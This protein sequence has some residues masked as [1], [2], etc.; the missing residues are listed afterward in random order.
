MILQPFYCIRAS[1]IILMKKVLLLLTFVMLQYFGFGQTYVFDGANSIKGIDTDDPVSFSASAYSSSQIDLEFKTN[2]Y[3]NN[4]VIVYDLDGSFSAP[5]G[6]PPAVGQAFA[7]GTLIYNGYGSDY[8]HKSLTANTQYYYKAWSVD[9][10]NVYS[11]GLTIDETTSINDQSV[12]PWTEDFENSGNIPAGW[13]SEFVTGTVVWEYGEG[14]FDDEHPTGAQGGTYN[15]RFFSSNKGVKTKIITPPLDLSQMTHPALFFWHTQEEWN[16]DQDELRLYYKNAANGKWTLI[17]GQEYTNSISVWT[18]ESNIDLPSPSAHYYIAFEGLANYGY[19][20]CVDNVTVSEKVLSEPSYHVF[21][22]TASAHGESQVNLTWDDNDGGSQDADGFLISGKT[23]TGSHYLPV[24]GTDPT[25]H[26][27]WNNDEFNVKVE[28][29]LEAYNVTG[30]SPSTTYDFKIYPYT[31][32]GSTIDYKTGGTIP[33]S[34]ATTTVSIDTDT[35]VTDPGSQPASAT[36]SSIN[37]TEISGFKIKIKD[38][39]SDGLPTHVTNIRLKPYTT[40]TAPW[41][42]NIQNISLYDGTTVIS[43]RWRSITD[44]YIDIPFDIGDLTIPNNGEKTISISFLLITNDGVT[45]NGIISFMVDAS[46][47]GFTA[48]PSGSTFSSSF[49]G[50]DFHSNNFTLNVIATKLTFKESVSDIPVNNIMTPF[51]TLAFTDK[52]E[53]VDLDYPNEPIQITAVGATLVGS[54]Q[55]VNINS[56]TG[57][58]IFNNIQFS[59]A[60]SDIYLNA[61]DIDNNLGNNTIERSFSF[62]VRDVG[63][64][65]FISEVA[66]PSDLSGGR[67]VELFNPTTS[68]IDLNSGGYYLELENN[69]SGTSYKVALKGTILEKSEYVCAWDDGQVPSS[70]FLT[71]VG[72]PN[73]DNTYWHGDGNDTYSLYK[74]VDCSSAGVLID[75]FGVSGEDGSGKNWEYTDSHAVRKREIVNPNTVWTTSEWVISEA[76]REQITPLY[77][78]KESAWD[79]S[80]SNSS[81]HDID[82]YQLGYIPDASCN[83]VIQLGS[84]PSPVI[85]KNA[86]CHNLKIASGTSVTVN[87]GTSLTVTGSLSSSGQGSLLL[88]ADGAHGPSS[89]IHNT[90]NVPATVESYFADLSKWYLLSPPIDNASASLFLGQYLDYWNEPTG[91][92]VDITNQNIV[93]IPGKGYSLKKEV[94][95]NISYL[96]NLNNGDVTISGLRRT[97]GTYAGWNLIGNPYPSVLAV[98]EMSFGNITAAVSVWP[99]NGA[100]YINYSKGTGGNSEARYIQPGQ[101]F[102]VQIPSGFDNQSLTFTN[103]MRTHD[104]LGSLDKKLNKEE[105]FFPM[106]LK[107]VISGAE[108]KKDET[109]IGFRE[110]ATKGFDSYYDVHKLF[111]AADVPHIFSYIITNDDE[112]LAIQSFPQPQDSDII[113]LGTRINDNGLYK[114][115]FNGMSS[116]AA[117]QA[118]VLLDHKTNKTYKIRRDSVIEFYHENSDDENRFDLLFKMTTGIEDIDENIDDFIIYINNRRLYINHIED[119]YDYI[120]VEIYDIL[121]QKLVDKTNA[122]VLNGIPLDLPSA[123]YIVKLRSSE[124]VRSTKFFIHE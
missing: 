8:E 112:E 84:S 49:S 87:A 9:I 38:S 61:T 18:E 102:M 124:I 25:D 97:S 64:D 43:H 35:E 105:D 36:I 48:E 4:I 109:Y 42:K 96:G 30:L 118:F 32:S 80:A 69:G 116:F 51:P 95:N 3:Q 115:K 2:T 75:R 121:G 104:G 99:H 10:C 117:N 65:V 40:N 71:Y 39:G 79:A 59:T 98:D 15:G 92:W 90:N 70:T 12:F 123:Y 44:D 52:N 101:G 119:L 57:K 66:D 120:H 67:F 33:S 85:S 16:V 68:D 20:V 19:G 11:T 106:L 14:G 86:F 74:G 58:A 72:L 78:A 53:N 55:T 24:D 60:G 88:K 89:L 81:W 93:L 27:N 107:I 111:G 110:L 83:L 56:S 13:S 47:H 103:N 76:D 26:T 22:F 7:G 46:S 1:N 41:T 94:N 122:N 17:W 50:G 113:H 73:Q 114:L 21:S 29:E 77:H 62:I 82:N 6:S 37:E 5:S 100:T 91:K 28:R 63:S 34:S 45:D 108:A 31:N 23:G 54:P